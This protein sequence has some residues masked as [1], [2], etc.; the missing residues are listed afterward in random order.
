VFDP[1]IVLHVNVEEAVEMIVHKRKVHRIAPDDGSGAVALQRVQLV[2]ELREV[3]VQAWVDPL[4]LDVDGALV[5]VEY[6]VRVLLLDNDVKVVDV[7]LVPG[8]IH[9]EENGSRR[10]V[11]RHELVRVRLAGSSGD[12]EF[13]LIVSLRVHQLGERVVNDRSCVRPIWRDQV[14]LRLN[15]RH[16]IRVRVCEDIHVQNQLKEL[17]EVRA[18]AEDCAVAAD[19]LLRLGEDEDTA[20]GEALGQAAEEAAL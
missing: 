14:P 19:G 12:V 4:T 16:K 18:A 2:L 9:I 1:R 6:T 15:G 3:Q 11:I 5:P 17:I 20:A 10:V 13:R 7:T 8:R